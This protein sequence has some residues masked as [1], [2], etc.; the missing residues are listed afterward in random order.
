MQG[1]AQERV[2]ELVAVAVRN[3][4]LLRNRLARQ[5][6]ELVR[7]QPGDGREQRFIDVRSGGRRDAEQVLG[8]GTQ[9]LGPREEEISQRAGHRLA[10]QAV[11]RDQLFDEERVALGSLH[12]LGDQFDRRPLTRD[13]L[14][15]LGDVRRG[16]RTQVDP[17]CMRGPAE[18]GEQRPQ[19]VIAIEIVGAVARDHEETLIVEVV[20]QERQQVARGAIGPMEV[21][22]DQDDRSI[23]R[24]VLEEREEREEE[25]RLV[26]RGL[27]GNVV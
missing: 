2:T 4:Q 25:R 16:E 11:G 5:V 12:H 6:D 24:E 3:E 18:F 22:E 7:R 1:L 15:L 13:G 9:H 26:D 10:V 23:L 21:L 14:E 19:R 27:G 8:R 17:L 20:G